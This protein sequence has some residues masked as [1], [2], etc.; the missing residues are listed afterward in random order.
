MVDLRSRAT[1]LVAILVAALCAVGAGPALAAPVT[2]DF[3]IEGK[4]ATHF[5]GPVTSDVRTVDGHD[6]SGPH[7]CDGT[8]N[9]QGGTPAPTAG[10]SLAEA[11][12]RGPFSFVASYFPPSAQGG[13]DLFL[14]TVNGETPDYSVDQTFW[15]FFVNGSFASVGMCQ[16]RVQP[17]DRILFARV[18]GSETILQLAGPSTVSTGQ[19]ATYTVTDASSGAP[20][21]GAGVGGQVTGADGTATATFDAPGTRTLKAT[22]ANAVRSNGV[23]TCVHAGDDGSC[24]TALPAGGPLPESRAPASSVLGLR[25]GA[26]FAAGRGPRLLKGHVDIGTAAL[27]AVRLRLRRVAAGRCSFWSVRAEKWRY[28][29]CNAGGFFYTIGD[30]AD[31]SYLLPERLGPG[32]YDLHAMAVDRAGLRHDA[33]VLFRVAGAR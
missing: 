23:T 32:R 28:R 27:A 31:W 25:S 15:G 22:R 21:A 29:P 19:P 3:R 7:T 14:N 20:V 13:D 5:D 24:G 30:R 8:N 6:N 33:Y 17:S 11:S 10:T 16:F 9:G 26:R 12:E 18:T 4:D 2:V 1:V